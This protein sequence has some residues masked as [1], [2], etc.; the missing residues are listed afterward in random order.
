M[1]SFSEKIQKHVSSLIIVALLFSSATAL[2]TPRRSSAALATEASNLAIVA[3]TAAIAGE[4]AISAAA[5]AVT[6]EKQTDD[7][8][9]KWIINP[10]VDAIAAALIWQMFD[11]INSWIQNGFDGKP[12]FVTDWE[13]YLRKAGNEAFGNYVDG[14][15]AKG[16]PDICSPFRTDVVLG[17][18]SAERQQPRCTLDRMVANVNSLYDNFET[19]GWTGFIGITTANVSNNAFGSV[20]IQMDQTTRAIIEKVTGLKQEAQASGG[21]LSWKKC[22]KY[23]EDTNNIVSVD[24]EENPIYGQKC[25]P[26][27]QQTVTPG[28]YVRDKLSIPDQYSSTRLAVAKGVDGLISALAQQLLQMGLQA[29]KPDGLAGSRVS[30]TP[31]YAPSFGDPSDPLTPQR[32]RISDTL[33]RNV[34]SQEN[35]YISTKQQS[36][37]ALEETADMLQKIESCGRQNRQTEIRNA[38]NNVAG[39]RA[40]IRDSKRRIENIGAIITDAS[41]AKTPQ[42]LTNITLRMT[43]A[44]GSA[45]SERTILDA[46]SERDNMVT[47]RDAIKIEFRQ[48]EDDLRARGQQ[49]LPVPPNFLTVTRAT[50]T[51]GES[52]AISW[53][54]LEGTQRCAASDGWVGEKNPEGGV[55]TVSPIVTTVYTLRCVNANLSSFTSA[56]VTI[57]V[58]S[59]SD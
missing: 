32:Q 56:S 33:N 27:A 42:E 40:D 18:V 9:T 44:L 1:Q 46:R 21:F 3:N 39:L 20:L 47:A 37:S 38:I 5:N 57:T 59:R 4:D 53:V 31:A 2:F 26:G 35:R 34:V 36:A 58:I 50:I 13:G 30:N 43:S 6:A 14:L 15:I 8:V 51:D 17:L 41:K 11:S 55:E 45:I 12:L 28:I 29:L 24:A 19:Y 25:A 7:W 10:L 49:C 16:A 54:P 48:L 23:V 52:S 22:T